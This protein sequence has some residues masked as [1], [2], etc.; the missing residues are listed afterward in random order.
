M[1]IREILIFINVQIC[2]VGMPPSH[3]LN[4]CLIF[5]NEQT[6]KV[7]WWAWWRLK[8]N[9]EENLTKHAGSVHAYV[10]KEEKIGKVILRK[11]ATSKKGKTHNGK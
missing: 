3:P 7:K 4:F 2:N 5:W 10:K 11:V 9:R 6:I 1:G 8:T